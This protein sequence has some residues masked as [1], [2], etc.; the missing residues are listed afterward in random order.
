MKIYLLILVTIFRSRTNILTK[1]RYKI[2][3]WNSLGFSPKKMIKVSGTIIDKL[4]LKNAAA[5]ETAN[6]LKETENF[7]RHLSFLGVSNIAMAMVFFKVWSSISC[8]LYLVIPLQRL[9][10]FVFWRHWRCFAI[11][12]HFEYFSPTH[13]FFHIIKLLEKAFQTT[14]IIFFVIMYTGLKLLW[15]VVICFVLEV[16]LS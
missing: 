9:H 4:Y 16:A 11:D 15:N 10:S 7:T 6:G 13:I 1:H 14:E 5:S 2:K 12:L 3:Q 8:N